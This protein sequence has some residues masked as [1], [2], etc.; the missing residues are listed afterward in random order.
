VLHAAC[1]TQAIHS[2]EGHRL[3]LWRYHAMRLLLDGVLAGI[4]PVSARFVETLDAPRRLSV[5]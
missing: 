4:N 2:N 3:P 1:A 5:V